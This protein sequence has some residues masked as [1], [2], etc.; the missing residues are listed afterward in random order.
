[1]SK[2]NGKSVINLSQSQHAASVEELRKTCYTLL[3]ENY[4]LTY[5]IPRSQDRRR[6]VSQSYRVYLNFLREA[7]DYFSC[8]AVKDDLL[9]IQ[10]KMLMFWF[11][12]GHVVG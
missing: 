1:M 7:T 11:Y 5:A 10:R 2:I 4:R 9:K 8:L 12:S 3:E 6:Y